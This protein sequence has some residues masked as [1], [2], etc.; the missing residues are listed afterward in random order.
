MHQ[1]AIDLDLFNMLANVKDE[2]K[3]ATDLRKMTSA[4][5]LLMGQTS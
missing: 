1:I 2:P 4:E 5:P 3:R